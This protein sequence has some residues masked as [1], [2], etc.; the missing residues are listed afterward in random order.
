MTLPLLLLTVLLKRQWRL[1]ERSTDCS[2]WELGT[3]AHFYYQMYD[4]H[5][6]YTVLYKPLYVHLAAKDKAIIS[7]N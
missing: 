2:K 7:N 5:R 6:V 3:R 1:S 4:L